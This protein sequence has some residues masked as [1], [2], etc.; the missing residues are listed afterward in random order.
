MLEALGARR[1]LVILT[2]TMALGV[3]VACTPR[4][5][6]R[7]NRPDLERVAEITPGEHSRE[8]V[9]EILGSPSIKSS[10]GQETWFYVSSKTETVVFLEPEVKERLVLSI[11]FD[12]EGVVKFI[13]QLGLEDGH[14]IELVERIS[15]TVGNE[16]TLMD[17]IFGNFG[18]FSVKQ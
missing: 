15:P 3:T 9:E 16:L 6:I 18:R 13:N 7:G 11:R 1:I 4:V 14:K 5:D 12:D 17:Q 10:F 2:V 8:L